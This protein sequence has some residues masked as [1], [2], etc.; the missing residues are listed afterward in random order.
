MDTQSA[1]I[2]ESEHSPVLSQ[3]RSYLFS[4]YVGTS[5]GGPPLRTV[6]VVREQ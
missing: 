6:M 5:H 2:G 3:G 1:V 4:L